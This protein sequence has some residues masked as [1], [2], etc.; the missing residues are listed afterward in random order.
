MAKKKTALKMK[1][2]AKSTSGKVKQSSVKLTTS[3][4]CREAI[5]VA[6][7]RVDSGYMDLSK[8]LHQAYYK[9]FYVEWGHEDFRSYCDAELGTDYRKAM[10]LV[11]IW[12]KVRKLNL[13]LKEVEAIGWSKMKEVAAVIDEKNAK[14]WLTKAKEMS[15]RDL[16][17][18]VR[19]VRKSD[20]TLGDTVPKITTMSLKMSESEAGII[21]DAIE[22]AKKLCENDNPVVALGMICQDWSESQGQAPKRASLEDHIKFLERVYGVKL[23]YGEE[24]EEPYAKR[25][26]PTPSKPVDIEPKAEETEGTNEKGDELDD[27]IDSL[28]EEDGDGTQ[29]DEDDDINSAL[30]L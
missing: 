16:Q 8:L 17:E 23:S 2:E 4:Q 18:A 6:R 24:G 27:D 15:A 9:E 20:G 1:T 5:L 3:E 14:E 28:L 19:L 25:V 12:D 13:P 10:Y 26:A 29:Q 30:G 11:D 22:E 21:L 7:D